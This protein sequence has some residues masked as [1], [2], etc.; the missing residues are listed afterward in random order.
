MINYM[1]KRKT[2][3]PNTDFQQPISLLFDGGLSSERAEKLRR[4]IQLTL[5]KQEKLVQLLRHEIPESRDSDSKNLLQKLTDRLSARLNQV[6][7]LITV[8]TDRQIDSYVKVR[9]EKKRQRRTQYFAKVL[10][11]IISD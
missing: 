3:E 5:A 2:R 8:F 9:R 7:T 6:E 10:N 11:Q 1:G 4:D